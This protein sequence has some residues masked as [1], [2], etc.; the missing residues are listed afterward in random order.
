MI[1]LK[2]RRRLLTLFLTIGISCSG[3]AQVN[4]D[5]SLK[6]FQSDVTD[7]LALP[8]E[9]SLGKEIFSASKSRETVFK[10]PLFSTVITRQELER[11]GVNS[12]AEAIR[13]VPGAIVREISNGVY[14]AG[15]R[16]LEN[17]LP[18]DFITF[19]INRLILVMVDGKPFHS[20]LSGG[21]FW[22][23]FPI[24]INDVEQIE[25]VQGPV[26]TLYGSNAVNGVINII[27]RKE[28]N[29]NL[30]ASLNSQMGSHGS[31]RL[32]SLINYRFPNQKFAISFSGN[33]DQRSRFDSDFYSF[34]RGDY[35][36]LDSL[37][38]PDGIEASDIYPRPETALDRFGL[39][40]AMQYRP[41]TNTT[42][43]VGGSL[44]ESAATKIFFSPPDSPMSF[45]ESQSYYLF[46][47]VQSGSLRGY[48][49]FNSGVRGSNNG[50]GDYRFQFHDA[51]LEYD[52]N[53]IDKLSI[54][55]SIFYRR[56][57]YRDVEG[58][59]PGFLNTTDYQFINSFAAGL[60]MDYQPFEKLRLIAGV[61]GE[62][63]DN[64]DN[65]FITFQGIV[66]YTPHPKHLI[67]LLIGRANTESYFA[68]NNL[69]LNTVQALEGSPPFT[70][71]RIQII[72]GDDIDLIKQDLIELGY[73][74]QLSDRLG[75][76]ISAY[77][78][79]SDDYSVLSTQSLDPSAAPQLVTTISFQTVD[80]EVEHLEATFTLDYQ[81][82]TFSV[83]PYITLQ[84]TTLKKFSPYHNST[85]VNP[86]NNLDLE[87][88]LDHEA[89]PSFYGGMVVNYRPVSALNIN[90]NLFFY[91]DHRFINNLTQESEQFGFEDELGA[92]IDG[93]FILNAKVMYSLN[94]Q[95]KVYANARNLFSNT[96]QHYF[97]DF[98]RPSYYFGFH[99]EL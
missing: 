72:G 20:H 45:S 86:V 9:S 61:R 15:I 19:S 16:G 21:T 22:E 96:Y 3:L 26:S 57:G 53:Q 62:K 70:S 47:E 97:T 13:L 5:D 38:L 76:E 12:L 89:T 33:A 37:V 11:T 59:I 1:S 18:F 93:R 28:F 63:F 56:V 25:V 64:P 66:N 82:K 23:T 80:T 42:I 78:S 34:M 48:Y 85:T 65:I 6:F 58:P 39:N 14:D 60:K 27:T 31:F 83:R 75:M 30:H 69:N 17:T 32:N 98:I 44:E 99:F 49:A 94:S 7:I 46:G 50:I 10:A 35:V 36:P 55:P 54:S 81:S 73:R 71:N 51:N 67:R 90:A 77:V 88:E 40:L 2:P 29:K 8:Y 43:R 95:L 92:G 4:P 91:D 52:F 87:L 68:L 84:K 24:D 79:R 41:G 74:T